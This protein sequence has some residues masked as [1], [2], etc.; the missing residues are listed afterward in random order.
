MEPLRQPD[1]FMTPMSRIRS[2]IVRRT[3]KDVIN[4]PVM[5]FRTLI[6]RIHRKSMFVNPLVNRP[7]F[8]K[9]EISTPKLAP[10]TARKIVAAVTRVK[11]TI[12]NVV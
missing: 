11:P 12:V 2:D 1:A 7:S 5:M 3:R 9:W 6:V 4:G 8:A 10:K